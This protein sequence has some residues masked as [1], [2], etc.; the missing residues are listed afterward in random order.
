MKKLNNCDLLN[1]NG[2]SVLGCV[3]AVVN[4]VYIGMA[5]A[6]A[7]DIYMEQR[8]IAPFLHMGFDIGIKMASW[9]GGVVLVG[10]S[11]GL[12]AVLGVGIGFMVYTAPEMK[13]FIG[14]IANA[15]SGKF[16]SKSEC[17][18]V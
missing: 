15:I 6:N 10:E 12:K 5:V 17:P 18:A 7:V 1:V 8:S 16:E 11:R 14:G 3:A 9:F 13:S 4:T 2:G